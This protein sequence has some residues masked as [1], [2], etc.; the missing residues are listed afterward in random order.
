MSILDGLRK[1]LQPPLRLPFQGVLTPQ[2][3]AGVTRTE[4]RPYDRT[5][6]HKDLFQDSP[7]DTT[8]RFGERED[9]VC[10]SPGSCAELSVSR[11]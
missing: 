8:D 6:G 4:I 3:L 2:G 7:V 9:A 5:L 10:L 11:H 1:R